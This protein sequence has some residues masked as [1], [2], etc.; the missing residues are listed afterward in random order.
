MALNLPQPYLCWKDK[1]QQ[2]ITKERWVEA[3]FLM[4]TFCVSWDSYVVICPAPPPSQAAAELSEVLQWTPNFKSAVLTSSSSFLL[5][6]LTPL[7]Q[8]LETR[9]VPVIQI[10]VNSKKEP[11][12][13][14]DSLAAQHTPKWRDHSA[15][16]WVID[17]TLWGVKQGLVEL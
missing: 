1:R 14:A 5:G 12:F 15:Y 10:K 6:F 11:S 17:M 13:L 9:E 2:D 3:H 4:P 7:I 8:L 16:S